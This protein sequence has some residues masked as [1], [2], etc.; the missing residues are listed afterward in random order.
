MN[1]DYKNKYNKNWFIDRAFLSLEKISDNTWD[2]SD[3]LLLYFSQGQEVY[4]SAHDRNSSYFKLVT[5]PEHLFL[6]SIVKDLAKKLPDKFDY[7]DLGV[8]VENKEK[9]FF[10]AFYEKK[11]EYL[12]VDISK[13]F[14]LLAFKNAQKSG[15]SAKCINSSFEELPALFED[16]GRVR[17]VTLLGL[18]FSNYDALKFLKLLK[19]IVG[20]GGYIFFDVQLRERIN[21][22]KLV[23]IYEEYM[24]PVCS[25]KI[26]LLGLDPSR[27]ILNFFV[28]DDISVWCKIASVNSGLQEKGLQVGDNLKVFQSLRPTLKSLKKQLKGFDYEVL[29]IGNSFVGILIRV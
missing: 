7:F 29:D 1:K 24:I 28:K 27:D 3:S 26:A 22:K 12:P 16:D 6:K 5:E 11:F 8:G 19:D 2:Y 18:T 25:Q 23:E 15:I 21:V 9:Y 10:E 4:S 13:Y 14:L 17:F 20:G